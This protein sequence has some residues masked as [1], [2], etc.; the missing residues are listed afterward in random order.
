MA[1]AQLYLKKPLVFIDLETTGINISTD[2]IVEISIHKVLVGNTTETLTLRVN[3]IIPIPL[4]A[5]LVHGIYDRDIVE[6]LTFKEHAFKIRDFIT[7]CDIAGFNS[8]RFD[9]PLLIEE[10]LRAGV[11]IDT[12]EIKFID[13]QRIFHMMEKRTL[14][15]AYKFYC[16]KELTNAHSAEADTIATYEVL[17]GQL[18]RYAEHLKNDID[19]LAD[20]SSDGKFV[21]FG[22]KMI[23]NEDGE[24][25]FNFGK[26]K[27]RLVKDVLQK[28]PQYYDWIQKS[29][30]PLDMKEKLKDLKKKYF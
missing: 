2:R 24:E 6:E 28:E 20:F 13:V 17:L 8:N 3:P 26:N 22:R 11:K 30:F 15:A 18:E 10:F 21:D 4:H 19:F 25:V 1:K 27:G 7:G 9:I 14:E 16:N 12:A 5:S 29:D 23:Y